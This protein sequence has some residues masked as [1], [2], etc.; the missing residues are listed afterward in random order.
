[1][2][3]AYPAFSTVL[4]QCTLHSLPWQSWMAQGDTLTQV[5]ARVYWSQSLQV[6]E[7]VLWKSP[8]TLSFSVASEQEDRIVQEEGKMTPRGGQGSGA[9]WCV[10]TSFSKLPHDLTWRSNEH[11]HYGSSFV[12]SQARIHFQK[13][14]IWSTKTTIQFVSH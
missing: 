7:H 5:E 9:S 11:F 14:E 1:M 8:V 13:W 10:P 6:I 2:V 12:Y 3:N 4:W